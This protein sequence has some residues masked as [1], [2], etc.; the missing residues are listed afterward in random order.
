MVARLYY[1]HINFQCMEWI[2]NGRSTVV[3]M[4]MFYWDACELLNNRSLRSTSWLSGSILPYIWWLIFGTSSSTIVVACPRQ[5]GMSPVRSCL[6]HVTGTDMYV[7]V[8]HT[9]AYLQCSIL[10]VWKICDV[11]TMS[12]VIHNRISVNVKIWVELGGTKVL[13][14]KKAIAYIDVDW[15]I[16]HLLQQHTNIHHNTLNPMTSLMQ[17]WAPLW[18]GSQIELYITHRWGL[19]CSTNVPLLPH[20]IQIDSFGSWCF[21]SVLLLHIT[22][23]GKAASEWEGKILIKLSGK[24]TTD[25]LFTFQKNV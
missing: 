4:Q 12:S 25:Y 6:G 5:D 2:Q 9:Y 13:T 11:K 20:S 15:G 18:Q 14:T 16:V 21:L 22:R 10:E 3:W 17:V 24:K 7:H 1:N 23:E 19:I 8:C